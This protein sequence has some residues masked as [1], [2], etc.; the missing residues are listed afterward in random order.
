M[1]RQCL[2]PGAESSVGLVLA[3]D[4]QMH[5]RDNLPLAGLIP[6]LPPLVRMMEVFEAQS[7]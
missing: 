6:L 4:R 5:V 1:S 2:L 3:D 7:A